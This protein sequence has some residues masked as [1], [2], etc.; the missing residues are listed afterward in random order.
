MCD[1]DCMEGRRRNGDGGGRGRGWREIICI[2][3]DSL[4]VNLP[5]YRVMFCVSAEPSGRWE[6]DSFQCATLCSSESSEIDFDPPPTP[7]P[8]LPSHPPLF[9]SRACEYERE[10]RGQIVCRALLYL[11]FCVRWSRHTYTQ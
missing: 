8:L 5:T 2:L 3:T 10:L 4:N 6:V 1:E 11:R 9:F 7:T